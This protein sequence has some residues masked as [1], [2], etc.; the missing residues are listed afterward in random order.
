MTRSVRILTITLMTLHL[1]TLT[2]VGDLWSEVRNEIRRS[3]ITKGRTSKW[4]TLFSGHGK[5]VLNLVER[6]LRTLFGR[7][8][9]S[10]AGMA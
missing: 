8:R 3:Q 5:G 1:T 9:S 10:T 4:V 2:A 7:S 6:K